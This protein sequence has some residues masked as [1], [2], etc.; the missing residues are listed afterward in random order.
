MALKQVLETR[1]IGAR[2]GAQDNAYIHPEPTSRSGF[3]RIHLKSQM[4]FSVDSI[5]HIV[6]NV[7]DVEACATWYVRVLSLERVDLDRKSVV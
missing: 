5:D 4:S 3:A 2:I 7:K 1:E 6:L